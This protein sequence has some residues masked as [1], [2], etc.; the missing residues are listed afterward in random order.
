[1]AGQKINWWDSDVRSA[2][3]GLSN[4]DIFCKLRWNESAK[5]SAA[6]LKGKADIGMNGMGHP[7]AAANGGVSAQNAQ[8]SPMQQGA[9][10]ATPVVQPL[11]V[12][13]YSTPMQ[14]LYHYGDGTLPIGDIDSEYMRMNGG[15]MPGVNPQ[16][17]MM[18]GASDDMYYN[19]DE[20]T[21]K[22]SKSKRSRGV[23]AVPI[24]VMLLIA[25]FGTL[26]LFFAPLLGLL[27]VEGLETAFAVVGAEKVELYSSIM[28]VVGIFT[29]ETTFAFDNYLLLAQCC[30]AVC[31]VLLAIT[32]ILS[33]FSI[34]RKKLPLFVRILV[35]LALLFMA[36]S[37]DLLAF[38]VE[39]ATL[40]L[41]CYVLGGLMLLIFII[42]LCGK[43]NKTK[44]KKRGRGRK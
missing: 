13:P 40:G 12:V 20:K 44:S 41:S 3:E 6:G 22:K 9:I 29:G 31:A 24:L 39:S 11:V 18:A 25:L 1:M 4:V 10:Q 5:R 36:G 32:F 14:P 37:I 27:K 2:P 38:L 30:L 16:G 35:I 26:Q 8:I 43:S 34:T 28:K 19:M 21:G 42:S 23:G 17:P 15:M 7:G 33:L